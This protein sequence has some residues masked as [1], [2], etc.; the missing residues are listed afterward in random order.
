MGSAAV[1]LPGPLARRLWTYPGVA[2]AA[3]E[4]QPVL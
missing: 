3:T 4:P 1:Q 2:F